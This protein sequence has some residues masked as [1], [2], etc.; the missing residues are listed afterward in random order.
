MNTDKFEQIKDGE[1]L[2][3]KNKKHQ[4]KKT[5]SKNAFPRDYRGHS[6]RNSRKTESHDKRNAADFYGEIFSG[7]FRSSGKGY[8][9]I[10]PESGGDDL[11]VPPPYTG[12]AMNGDT[13]TAQRIIEKGERGLGSEAAVHD[14]TN[15]AHSSIIGTFRISGANMW[16]EPDDSLIRTFVHVSDVLCDAADGDKVEIRILRY[17]GEFNKKRITVR[18]HA[19]LLPEPGKKHRHSYVAREIE[20][21]VSGE[22][23]ENLG[24]AQSR[25]ANYEAILREQN[26][27]TVFS[28]EVIR[29]AENAAAEKIDLCGRLDLRNDTIFTIDGENAKDP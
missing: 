22:I 26:I 8:G 28:D 15:R 19:D 29:E 24:D 7:I 10:T 11:F 23:T 5:Q 16:V 13:V 1:E 21:T 2:K 6:R 14:V 4:S 12:D 20:L 18:E 17:P 27:R 3:T 9:F 25:G